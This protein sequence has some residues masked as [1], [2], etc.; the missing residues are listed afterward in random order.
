MIASEDILTPGADH[1]L[2]WGSGSRNAPMWHCPRA[3]Y[4]AVKAADLI[5][6]AASCVI[7]ASPTLGRTSLKALLFSELLQFLIHWPQVPVYPSINEPGMDE[8]RVKTTS[9]PW[10][11]S[12][13][14][15]KPT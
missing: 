5:P 9:S 6:L 11:T 4:A 3:N 1:S 12:R 15:S 7:H 2:M 8:N 10:P 13:T 14:T